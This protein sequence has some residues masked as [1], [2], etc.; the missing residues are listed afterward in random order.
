MS[1]PNESKSSIITWAM[2]GRAYH[3]IVK[4]PFILFEIAL[5]IFYNITYCIARI[6]K[7]CHNKSSRATHIRNWDTTLKALIW[8][9]GQ[10]NL[11]T[12]IKLL[13]YDKE[14]A[15]SVLFRFDWY[16]GYVVEQRSTTHGPRAASGSF[17]LFVRSAK[18]SN[19][20][21]KKLTNLVKF[22][23]RV[24]TGDE[25]IRQ[26]TTR[27]FLQSKN[28]HKNNFDE[29]YLISFY[30]SMPENKFPS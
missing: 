30:S 2:R 17:Q 4:S 20:Y 10:A 8:K 24:V 14:R 21:I 23:Q 26:F 12:K 18:A 1:H 25:N 15:R 29:N 9:T 28:V 13:I 3:W 6:S 22:D 11:S 5:R 16:F 19:I 7:R 27:V